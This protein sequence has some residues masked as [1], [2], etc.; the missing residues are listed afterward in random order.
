MYAYLFVRN[1]IKRVLGSL[2]SV[3]LLQNKLFDLLQ[4]DLR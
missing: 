4:T 1:F 3:E 2:A